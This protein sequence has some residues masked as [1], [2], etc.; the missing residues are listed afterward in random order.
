[1]R[2]R[3]KE[4]VQNETP[5]GRRYNSRRDTEIPFGYYGSL[6][7]RFGRRRVHSNLHLGSRGEFGR[8]LLSGPMTV[9]TSEYCLGLGPGR[10][11][12]GGPKTQSL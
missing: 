5:F 4:T 6:T 3:E 7:L 1:M 12:R 2:E 11:I 10:S 9:L 8:L